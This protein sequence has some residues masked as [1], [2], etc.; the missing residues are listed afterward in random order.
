MVNMSLPDS[1]F[2]LFN[3]SSDILLL[4]VNF[5]LEY[6]PISLGN[7]SHGTRILTDQSIP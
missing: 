5:F 2:T 7:G 4:N 3:F 6:T 1:L